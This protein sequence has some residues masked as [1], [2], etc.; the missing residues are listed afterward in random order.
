MKSDYLK[1]FPVAKGKDLLPDVT[2]DVAFFCILQNIINTTKVLDQDQ[3]FNY[4]GDS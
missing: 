1:Y 2:L 4:S 3:P